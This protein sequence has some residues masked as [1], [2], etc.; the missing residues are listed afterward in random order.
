M[1]VALALAAGMLAQ[2]L[3]THTRLPGIVVL[4]AAGVVLGP[5]VAGVVRPDTLGGGLL[6]LVGFAV[7]VILFEGGLNL[8]LRRLRRAQRPIRQLVTIGALV[9]A[10]GGTLVARLVMGWDW[11]LCVL[12]GTLVIVTGPTVITPLLRRLNVQRRVSTVLEAEGVLV[13]AVGA[14][15]A[16]VAME[17]ALSPSTE[18]LVAG[19]LH[20]GWRLGFGTLGGFLGGTVIALLLRFRRVIPEG[21]ENVLTLGMAL[22]IYETSNA[23]MHESG[24]AAV[25]VAGIVVGNSRTHV[26]RELAEFKEQLTVL[27][28][29][30]LFILLAADVRFDDVVALGWPGIATVVLLMVLVRPLN[31]AVGTFRTDL[32][33]RERAF[34]AWIGPRGIVAAAVASLFALELE[35]AEIPGSAALRPLVFLVITVTVLWAGLTGGIAARFLGV[36]RA[37]DA[38]WFILGATRLPRIMARVLQDENHPVVCVDS[39]P[40]AVRATEEEGV[41][42]LLGNALEE[43]TIKRAELDTRRGVLAL[44]GKAEVNLLFAQKARRDARSPSYYV[45]LA[46]WSTGVTQPMVAEQG[47]G[48]LFDA[49]VDLDIWNARL[50]RGTAIL[51]EWKRRSAARAHEALTGDEC[52]PPFVGLARSRRGYVE[53]VDDGM[54]FRRRDRVLFLIDEERRD[55]AAEHLRALGWSPAGEA[56]RPE[57]LD[58]EPAMEPEPELEPEGESQAERPPAT[59]SA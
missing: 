24:I 22:L 57:E 39:D 59:E 36:R 8:K 27:L 42:A 37:R 21:L 45:Q 17:V 34:I 55:Q 50:A 48:V 1:T 20:I 14:I 52:Y 16:A 40:E 46:D 9:T 31:V 49:A 3:A 43:R 28:I 7:A 51:Q 10:T 32:S 12:F 33:L 41:R 15:T 35:A 26:H 44:S 25:T 23:V 29:G 56:F 5:D 19:A 54:R 38:G 58:P 2:T 30:M 53:P 18:S 13:D 11:R 47:M 6:A 4:L